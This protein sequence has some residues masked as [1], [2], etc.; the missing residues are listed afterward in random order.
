MYE[1]FKSKYYFEDVEGLIEDYGTKCF[2]CGTETQFKEYNETL[3]SIERL[4]NDIGHIKSNCV[5]CCL[6][7]NR[8]QV[9][10]RNE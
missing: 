4:N 8:K 2:Y 7:C 5:L 1:Y 10:Q 6:S 9:G 3:I